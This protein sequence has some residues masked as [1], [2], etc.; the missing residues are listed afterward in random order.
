MSPEELLST[1]VEAERED[2]GVK[3]IGFALK[4]NL[5]KTAFLD[6]PSRAALLEIP[7]DRH[8]R[9]GSLIA[10]QLPLAKRQDAIGDA[11]IA[12]AI[13]DRIVHSSHRLELKGESL[14]KVYAHRDQQ[15]EPT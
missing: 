4:R 5:T 3:D 12:D 8:R 6:V 11:T 7:E 2:R 15:E 14:S 10:S 1:P 13:C 9:I